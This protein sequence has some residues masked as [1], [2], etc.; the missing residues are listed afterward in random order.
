MSGFTHAW[1]LPK[2]FNYHR[3]NV[4]PPWNY[5]F[6]EWERFL[7]SDGQQSWFA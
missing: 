6:L 2:D 3:G 7:D 4:F 5:A 1:L